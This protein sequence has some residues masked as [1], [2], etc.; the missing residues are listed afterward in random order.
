MQQQPFTGDANRQRPDILQPSC[1]RQP[2]NGG[3]EISNINELLRQN[4]Q[5]ELRVNTGDDLAV[6]SAC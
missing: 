1:G 3:C 2:G 6:L 4:Q 5:Q